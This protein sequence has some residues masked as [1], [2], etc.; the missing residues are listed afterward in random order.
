MSCIMKKSKKQN[1]I[2]RVG[3]L[4]VKIAYICGIIIAVSTM[5]S[6]ICFADEDIVKVN[7]AELDINH[8]KKVLILNSYHHGHPW[9]D[10]VTKGILETFAER[11]VNIEVHIENMDTKRIADTTSWMDM[12]KQKLDAYPNGYL[13]LII[14]SG[15]NA[16]NTLYKIGHHYHTIPIVYCGISENEACYSDL[17][18]MFIEVK[19]YLPFKE[20]IEL[21]LRLFPNT[22]HIAIVTDRSK[23]G[24]SCLYAAKKSLKDMDLGT[25]DIIWLNGYDGL[26]TAELNYRLSNLPENTIVILSIWQ[27]DGEGKF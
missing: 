19:E 14:V 25:K 1:F 16:L 11:N 10:G 7:T 24:A 23:T 17:C 5:F 21:G 20:N 12:L 18:S 3:H 22:E 6:L 4:S 8:S 9:T 15:D 27:I 2:S 13:D 26:N